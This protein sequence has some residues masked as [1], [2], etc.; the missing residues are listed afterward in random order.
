MALGH[1]SD[2][3]AAIGARMNA[4]ESQENV[5]ADYLVQVDETLSDTQDLDY[6]EAI[7]RLKK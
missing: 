1:I 5:N 3:Q 4:T 2:K 7:S 6:T